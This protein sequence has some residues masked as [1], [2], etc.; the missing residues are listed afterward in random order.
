MR[1]GGPEPGALVDV[2]RLLTGRVVV[3]LLVTDSATI[4]VVRRVVR[5]V[6]APAPGMAG[7]PTGVARAASGRRLVGRRTRGRPAA[8]V[9]VGPERR[10]VRRPAVS[11]AATRDGATRV[12]PA[13]ARGARRG[14]GD[15]AARAV[16]VAL[17]ASPVPRVQTGPVPGKAARRPGAGRDA[18]PVRATAAATPAAPVGR[19]GRRDPRTGAARRGSFAVRRGPRVLVVPE[20]AARTSVAT[21]R[22]AGAELRGPQVRGRRRTVNVALAV[23]GV[24]L[25]PALVDLTIA[26]A[27]TAGVTTVPGASVRVTTVPGRTGLARAGGLGR[28]AATAVSRVRRTRRATVDRRRIVPRTV[29]FAA[30]VGRARRSTGGMTERVLVVLMAAPQ[31]RPRGPRSIAMDDRRSPGTGV[32]APC[33]GTVLRLPIVVLRLP[34]VATGVPQEIGARAVVLGQPGGPPVRVVRV[35]NDRTRP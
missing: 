23:R 16:P 14:A 19:P 29:R 18:P 2:G 3:G 31:P 5:A 4:L 28:G 32:P 24:T 27:T 15:R 34:I 35:S 10:A 25:S 22:R 20:Q 11:G 21:V 33:V 1:V 17:R 7:R 12:S 13:P 8:R 30:I 9:P 6:V 26:R